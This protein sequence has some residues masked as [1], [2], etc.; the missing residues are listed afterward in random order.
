MPADRTP[1][2]DLDALSNHWRIALDLAF[3]GLKAAERGSASL[4][5]PPGELHEHF[6]R[7]VRERD[8]T[9]RLIDEIALE[10]HV[11]LRHRLSLPRATRQMLDLPAEVLGC[12]F[13]LDGVL[14]GSAHVH[15]EAWRQTFDEFLTAWAERTGEPQFAIARFTPRD[16]RDHIHGRPRLEGVLAFL[17]SRGIRLDDSSVRRLAVRKGELMRE[18]IAEQG[19]A[20]FEGSLRFLEAAGEA[21]LGCAVVTASANADSIIASAGL[22]A[23]LPRRIDGN[24]M[25]HEKLE[26][27]PRPDSILAAC[28]ELGLPPDSVAGFETDRLGIEAGRAAGLCYTIGVDR[29][30]RAEVLR[31]ARVDRIVSDLSEL[32][33]P[34]LA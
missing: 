10:E 27:K 6:G 29:G 24:T 15:Q 13:D 32:L 14:V 19:V 12:V 23:L 34:A 18:L 16:Y 11:H 31:E 5:I 8:D 4:H 2:V 30:G 9:A 1:S 7:L 3:D 17:A 26:G 22:A 33:D 25:L 21:G 20:A 28:K